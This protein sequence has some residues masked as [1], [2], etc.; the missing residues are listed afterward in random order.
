MTIHVERLIAFAF[1]SLFGIV[2]LAPEK[3]PPEPVVAAVQRSDDR[4]MPEGDY[5]DAVIDALH[6][7][8]LELEREVADW[9]EHHAA[10][11]RGECVPRP[12][13]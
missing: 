11:H 3:S 10:V 9:E 12:G 7:R 1:L 6:A 2:L 13:W 8:I 5:R 4:G